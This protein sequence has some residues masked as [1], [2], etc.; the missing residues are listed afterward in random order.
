MDNLLNGN[1]SH[2]LNLYHLLGGRA[3]ASAAA[4][5]A[6]VGSVSSARWTSGRRDE[7]VWGRPQWRNGDLMAIY[8]TYPL[9]M[10]VLDGFIWF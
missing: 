2:L 4:Y 9:E 10:A 3:A 7:Q 5:G 8:R 1:G 6:L